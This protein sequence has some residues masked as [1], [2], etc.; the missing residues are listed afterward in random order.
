M[1]K[2]WNKL[3]GRFR[4]NRIRQ[5][6]WDVLSILIGIAIISIGWSIFQTGDWPGAALNFGTDMV[7][8]VVI[9]VLL[10]IVLGTRQ[11]K[12]E[13]IAQM[14]SRV[15]DVALYAV[16]ELRRYNGLSDGSLKNVV[17]PSANLEGAVLIG[18]DLR[19][20]VLAQA[21]LVGADL[22]YA[23]LNETELSGANLEGANLLGAILTHANLSS[24]NLKGAQLER[25]RL[26]GAELYDANLQGTNLDGVG[27]EKAFLKGA[28]YNK[29]T[30]WPNEFDP[31]KAGAVNTTPSPAD[32]IAFA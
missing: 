14:G 2:F 19:G 17:L 29:D 24:A 1:K 22:T 10:D 26:E 21:I 7:G 15:K 23:K 20:S 13:L 11:R 5:L 32:L 8:A 18:A 4:R 6:P 3:A 9:Y 25:A 31:E 16:E 12:E 28:L 27:L 30:I